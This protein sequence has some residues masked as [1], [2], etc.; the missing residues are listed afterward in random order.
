MRAAISDRMHRRAARHRFLD[1]YC[2]VNDTVRRV[3][4]CIY[5]VVHKQ[6]NAMSTMRASYFQCKRTFISP[7]HVGGARNVTPSLAVHRL[8]LIVAL[9]TVTAVHHRYIA[10]EM[11]LAGSPAV[12][13]IY[14]NI[15]T[16]GRPGQLLNNPSEAM[17]QWSARGPPRGSSFGWR[18]GPR[19]VI[20]S[21]TVSWWAWS[22]V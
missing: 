21:N 17:Q 18:P 11:V 22:S 3:R 15:L 13:R 20:P 19:G 1:V 16:H 12:V 5:S 2:M 10:I 8:W 14:P 6:S 4:T 9:V 7:Q